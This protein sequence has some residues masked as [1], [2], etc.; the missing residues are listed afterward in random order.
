[1]VAEGFTNVDKPI[2]IA[3]TKYEAAAE[4]KGISAE[5]VLAMT[6]GVCPFPGDRIVA[7][8]QMQKRPAP[9]AGH[10]IRLPVLVDQQRKRNASLFAEDAGVAHVAQANGGDARSLFLELILMFAQ[11]RDMLA[12]KHSAIM[13]QKG[14]D[15]GSLVPERA[16]A[17]P[18]TRRIGQQ[19][20]RQ[21]STYGI[22]HNSFIVSLE[23]SAVKR[24]RS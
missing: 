8:K 5:A 20:R 16:K 9:H 23:S 12:A 24:D 21:T 18:V 6:R 3:G 2:H 7:A 22:T 15:R 1:M 13:A 14:N 11:L 4:L 17:N 19:N 10:A